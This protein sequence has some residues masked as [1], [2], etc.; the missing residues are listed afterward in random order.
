MVWQIQTET[1]NYQL[2]QLLPAVKVMKQM[3]LD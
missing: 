2:E 1:D 3:S